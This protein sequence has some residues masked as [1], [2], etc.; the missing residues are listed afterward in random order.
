MKSI[1]IDV[2]TV[3][4]AGELHRLLKQKLDFPAY[5]GE[6]WDAF[7]DLIS[8]PED[9]G[10]PDEIIWIGFAALQRKLPKEAEHLLACLDDYHQ[11]TELQPCVSTFLENTD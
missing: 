10:L 9:D 8:D 2:T 3:Q 5:Y 1:E 11:E 6:N 7:W 4:S